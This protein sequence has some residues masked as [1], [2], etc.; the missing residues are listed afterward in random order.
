MICQAFTTKNRVQP[1]AASAHSSDDSKKAG[2]FLQHKATHVIVQCKDC[3]NIKVVPCKPG[4]GSAAIP[5]TCD[6]NV[7]NGPGNPDSCS[8]DPYLVLAHKSRFVDTQRLKLQVC[9]LFPRKTSP[10]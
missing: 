10:F 8:L 4:M 7:Q 9:L 5:R 6:A 2:P 3:K 1:I